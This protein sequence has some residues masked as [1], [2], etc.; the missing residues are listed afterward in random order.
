MLLVPKVKPTDLDNKES[1]L[2]A[3][4]NVKINKIATVNWPGQFPAKPT[5]AFKI[6]HTGD[7]ILLQYLVEEDEILALT[8]ED[9]GPVWT[10]S[11]VEFFITL[12]GSSNYYNLEC[13]CTGTALLAFRPGREGAEHAN[14]GVM[15]L[16]SRY[17]SLGNEPIDKKHGDF[18]WNLLL[19]IP[20]ATFWKSK[21]E[22]FDGIKAK[23]N[24]Y[25]CGDNLS[26][27]HFLSWNPIRIE[28]PDFHRPEYFAELDFE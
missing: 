14:K 13:N 7:H 19:V 20:A 10:D 23:A 1:V 12:P 3:L 5:V 15:S 21:L 9:N 16:I 6:A 2:A 8:K 17:P 26:V 27:P 25:K 11:C 18:K 22:S 4:A 24:F 28:N